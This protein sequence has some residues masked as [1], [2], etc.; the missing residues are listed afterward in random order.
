MARF[1][2]RVEKAIRSAIRNSEEVKKRSFIDMVTL[3]QTPV[4]LGGRM[5]VATGHLR[6]SLTIEL[7]GSST[8]WRGPDAQFFA[9]PN[10]KPDGWMNIV[11]TAYYASFQE[12]GT[13]NQ[14][15]R[16]FARNAIQ[17]LGAIVRRNAAEIGRAR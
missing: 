12:N 10:L 14:P 17:Q 16:H 5:P 11:W 13:K 6:E 3:A 1:G 2:F 15:P 9:V 4:D 8:L 7:K